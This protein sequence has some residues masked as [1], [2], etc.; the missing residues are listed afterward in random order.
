MNWNFATVWE[1]V[2][3]A[4]PDHTALVQ[5]E[6]R[7]TWRE[8]DDRA[9]RLAS[10]MRAAGLGTGSKVASYLYNGNE[11][12]EGVFASFKLRA[13]PV[14]VNYRYLE[15]EL[16]YMLDNSDAEALLFHGS[17]GDRVAKVRDRAPKVKLWV[18]VDD[19]SPQQEFAVPYEE[20]LANNEPMERI[21]RSGDDYY[22]LYTGGTTGMPKGVMW[23]NED[24]FGVLGEAAYPLVGAT[25]PARAEDAGAI[26][27]AAVDTMG[28][29]V[30]LPASPLMHGTGAFTTFQALFIGGTIVTL[31][32]RHFDAHELWTTVQRE[33][34]TQMAIVGDAFAKPMLRALEEREESGEPYDA[35]S[36]QLIIS[37]GVIWTSEVKNGL[38]AR[39]N[40]F[41][42]D[43]LG[44]SEGVGFAN[45]TSAPGSEQATAKFTIGAHA[46]VLKEDGSEVEPGSDD[47]GLLALGGYLPTGYYKDE[48]KSAATF[49]M[50]NNRRWSVPGDFA[51]VEADGTIVL[52]GRGSVVINSGGE[53]IFPEEVEEAVKLH[54]AVADC[55]VV[56]VPDDRF[57]EAVTAVVGL[58]PGVD[59]T[60]DDITAALGAL[61]RFK[62]PRNY[63]FVPDVLRSPNGKADYRWA[64]E[65]AQKATTNG[66]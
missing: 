63:V 25:T 47:I 36:V 52:L 53:K 23:R 22:F 17:L 10:G 45:S 66:I 13:V 30:H 29:R 21:E 15:D 33:G 39:A 57:G 43:S 65:T 40:C 50:L 37:S 18:Q 11:Y 46:K 56:G 16:V 42:L 41:C 27:K 35:S 58:R 60:G 31:E 24:L 38:M 48:T 61:A 7:R 26:A 5:G 12:M 32:G 59:A 9:S 4:L 19:G 3:D 54:P 2:G 44:S 14:N 8:F 28:Q 49:R 64:K 1:S 6:R 34:V 51:R 62:H 55:L 20:L